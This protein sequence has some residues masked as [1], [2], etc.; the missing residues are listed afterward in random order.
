MNVVQFLTTSFF[1]NSLFFVRRYQHPGVG[2]GMEA[3]LAQTGGKEIPTAQ[4]HASEGGRGGAIMLMTVL[5][6]R[7]HMA[8]VV[9]NLH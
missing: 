1:D 2:V 4:H 3:G 9:D 6:L 7:R 8:F 5:Q